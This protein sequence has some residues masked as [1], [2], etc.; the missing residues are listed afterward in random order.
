M[1]LQYVFD[2]VDEEGPAAHKAAER[3]AEKRLAA[4]AAAAVKAKKGFGKAR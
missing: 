4:G 1:A 3:A 2:C